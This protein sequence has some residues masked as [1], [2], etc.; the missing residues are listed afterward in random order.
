MFLRSSI[1]IKVYVSNG[2]STFNYADVK[3]ERKMNLEKQNILFFVKTMNMG[4]TSNVILQLCKILQPHVKKIVVCSV[5]GPM[6]E[7]LNQMGIKHIEVG[8]VGKHKLSEAIKILRQLNT[9]IKQENITI[10]H[11]HHRMSAFYTALLYKK[12]RFKF[13]ST[14]HNTFYDN[15]PMTKFAYKNANVIACGKMVKRNLVEYFGIP[16]EQVTVI[17]NAVESYNGKL[18][19]VDMLRQLK[20]DGYYL[21]A[22]VGR[23][24][25]QKGMEYFIDSYPLVKKATNKIKYV[26]IGD[27]E[28]REKLKK[29]IAELGI[30]DDVK[31]LGFRRDVQNVLSQI[32]LLVLSSLWEGLPLTPIEGFS[33]GKTVVATA[34]D[35]TV[36]IVDDDKNGFLIPAKD[37]KAIAEKVLYLFEHQEIQKQFEHEAYCT[38]E[39]EFCFEKFSEKVIDYY[40][41][42]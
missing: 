33:V 21:V 24:A 18:E 30:Q 3:G 34:V 8:N 36:E 12:G 19:I 15:K 25:E 11:T 4:G 32:D 41:S 13:I 29:K 6:V 1:G 39:K 10:V 7:N 20:N 27:G 37:P 26:L 23:F 40:K 2:Q 31:F 14:A 9:I 28:D 22:N 5:G 38:F 35:G 16:E 17:H 42:C